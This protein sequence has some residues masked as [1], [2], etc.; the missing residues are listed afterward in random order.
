MKLI[1]HQ[2]IFINSI[3]IG[4]ITQSSIFQIGSAGIIKSMTN[5]H[6]TGGFTG[7]VREPD[8]NEFPTIVLPSPNNIEFEKE[9]GVKHH[10]SKNF[11][12]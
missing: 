3:K 9:Q 4:G 6:N 7:P 2:S 5:L 1:V 8:Y 12:S 10:E 11:N